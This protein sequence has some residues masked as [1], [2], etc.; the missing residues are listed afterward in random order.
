M[1]KHDKVDKKSR[2]W[3]FSLK[4]VYFFTQVKKVIFNVT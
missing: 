2:G 1:W 3:K 4:M